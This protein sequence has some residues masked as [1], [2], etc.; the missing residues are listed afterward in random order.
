[1]TII[2]RPEQIRLTPPEL[3]GTATGSPAT[4]VVRSVDYYGHDA[5]IELELLPTS[6][7]VQARLTGT[8]V[9]ATGTRAALHV[10]GPAQPFPHLSQS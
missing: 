1:I 4:G 7:R 10:H 2:L 6:D 3:D 5:L 8:P 9:P